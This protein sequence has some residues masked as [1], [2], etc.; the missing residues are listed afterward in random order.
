MRVYITKYALTEGVKE[1]ETSEEEWNSENYIPIRGS[2]NSFRKDRHI[3]ADRQKA[4]AAAEQ[5]RQKK[6][7]SLEK[8]IS[9]L[10][11]LRFE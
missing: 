3:F 10:N 4:M 1:A 6:I 8:S 2:W 11:K 7:K 5:M 9:K